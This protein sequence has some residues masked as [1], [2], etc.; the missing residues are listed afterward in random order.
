MWG[1]TNHPWRQ[2]VATKNPP[3]CQ[4][5][6]CGADLCFTTRDQT[7][8]S[9]LVAD[10]HDGHRAVTGVGVPVLDWAEPVL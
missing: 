9:G 2:L 3:H 6:L 7:C 8:P 1:P 5:K 4:P 10:V